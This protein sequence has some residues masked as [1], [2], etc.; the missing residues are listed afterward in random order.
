MS[1]SSFVCRGFKLLAAK[2]AKESNLLCFLR[3]WHTMTLLANRYDC[4]ENTREAPGGS[5]YGDR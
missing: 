4:C 1:P 3:I 5:K 2:K